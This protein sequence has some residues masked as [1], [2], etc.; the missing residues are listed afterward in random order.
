MS[1]RTLIGTYT[2][3]IRHGI[4]LVPGI[5]ALPVVVHADVIEVERVR[6]RG[7]V[8]AAAVHTF[9]RMATEVVTK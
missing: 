5:P 9:T 3:L 6:L 7:I 8:S 2:I 1:I 4:V